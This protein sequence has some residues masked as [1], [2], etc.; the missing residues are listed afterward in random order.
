MAAAW[1]WPQED[2]AASLMSRSNGDPVLMQLSPPRPWCLEVIVL[3]GSPACAQCPTPYTQLWPGE[4]PVTPSVNI[5]H[6]KAAIPAL[7]PMPFPATHPAL[8]MARPCVQPGLALGYREHFPTS[9][10]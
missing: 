3:T 2:L 4:G 9:L 10:V 8:G 7:L 5:S 6:L 1:G